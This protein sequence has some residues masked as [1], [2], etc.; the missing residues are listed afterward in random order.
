MT[1]A[2]APANAHE[3]PTPS[4][5]ARANLRNFS[6]MVWIASP[7][8]PIGGDRSSVGP[9]RI[10]VDRGSRTHIAGVIREER[11]TAHGVRRF[12]GAK[13]G[14]SPSTPWRRRVPAW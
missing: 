13:S 7:L 10:R 14:R 8:H 5:I 3:E 12:V 2:S 4:A 9:L 11:G 6:L 1:T